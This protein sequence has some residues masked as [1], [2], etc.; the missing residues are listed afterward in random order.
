MN[1]LNAF[2]ENSDVST[3]KGF[4]YHDLI[5][6]HELA[7]NLLRAASGIDFGAKNREI[8]VKASRE[9]LVDVIVEE[10]DIVFM[11]S[12]ERIPPAV[13]YEIM[14]YR[15][16]TGRNFLIAGYITE[17]PYINQELD[18]VSDWFDVVFTNELNDVKR[19]DPNEEKYVFYLPH[20]F[21]PARHHTGDV[22]E[23]FQRDVF[24]C[25]SLFPERIALLRD[26]AWE[27]IDNPLIAGPSHVK[28]T[29]K[30][31]GEEL[32]QWA[33]DGL[34]SNEVVD[35]DD[36]A[37]YYRGSKIVI[38]KHRTFG[39]TPEGKRLDI[40]GSSAYSTGPRLLEVAGC[41]GFS[42]TDHRPEVEDIF[43]DSVPTFVD[44]E[45]LN[46]LI[47]YYLEH[48]EERENMATEAHIR[49]SE[50]TYHNRAKFVMDILLEATEVYRKT[51][52]NRK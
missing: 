20:A 44:A 36:L 1:W 27:T 29:V 35:N 21:N 38:N 14:K 24:F 10:P 8:I 51:G 23:G 52:G 45:H 17:A 18:N 6:Y 33:I 39:W 15:K 2:R 40:D 41:G 3:C 30:L 4:S 28:E 12:G 42:L 19:R 16:E 37:D 11:V 32:G 25:G 7:T 49:A 34:Y 46:E 26:L 50:H 43:G 31:Y 22:S 9:L 13:F 47:A 5:T 48:K